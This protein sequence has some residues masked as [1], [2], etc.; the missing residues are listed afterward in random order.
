M[1]QRSLRS[2]LSAICASA[3]LTL[4]ACERAPSATGATGGAPIVF[5]AI[6]PQAFFVERIAGSHA[7]V[8][9]LAGPGQSPHTYEPTPQQMARMAKARLYFEM[10]L[11]FEER[12][13]QQIRS[14]APRCEIV[15]TRAGVPP[16]TMTEHDEHDHA[17]HDDHGH[18]AGAPDPHIWLDPKRVKIQART[19]ADALAHALPEF[20]DDFEKNL[21]AFTRELDELDG[22]LTRTL[23]PLKGR[24]LYVYHPAY[25]YFADSYGLKQVAI[26]IEGK[27]PSP[28]QLKQ[29]IER[30][31]GAGTRALFY[32]PQY[33]RTT[34]DTM[35]RELGVIPVP[36]DEL[37]HDYMENLRG[38]ARTI[39]TALA[40]KTGP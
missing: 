15:D 22:E 16:L 23:A 3:L 26:E 14:A 33:A 19:I 28:R 12:V 6:P 1:T 40:E 17:G 25:G 11:G 30:A 35:A 2:W 20:R 21:A 13:L 10:G 37:S 18:E 24:E 31:R 34:I 38:M 7:Q 8:E 5:A 36:L 27:E 9:F 39:R 4:A 32:Q 29:V